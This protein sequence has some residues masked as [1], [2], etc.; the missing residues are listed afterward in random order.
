MTIWQ[1]VFSK[2][3]LQIPRF[4]TCTEGRDCPYFHYVLKQRVPGAVAQGKLDDTSAAQAEPKAGAKA[5]RGRKK[6]TEE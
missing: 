2:S 3:P 1:V 5:P 6:K 4:G